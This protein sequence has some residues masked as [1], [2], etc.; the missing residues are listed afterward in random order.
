MI[1]SIYKQLHSYFLLTFIKSNIIKNIYVK[2]SVFLIIAFHCFF[3][4]FDKSVWIFVVLSTIN[5]W[6]K[7]NQIN[8]NIF[9]N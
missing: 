7:S 3:Y 4:G 2:L 1:T 8:L 5:A 6:N 9:D